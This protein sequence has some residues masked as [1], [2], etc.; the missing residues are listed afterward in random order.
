[1]PVFVI[2]SCMETKLFSMTLYCNM[3]LI[4]SI[5]IGTRNSMD[6]SLHLWTFI[7]AWPKRWLELSF[8]TVILSLNWT[9]LEGLISV[10]EEVISQ[11]AER[12]DSVLKGRR[13]FVRLNTRSPKDVTFPNSPITNDGYEALCW[14]MESNRTRFDLEQLWTQRLPSAIALRKPQYLDEC[15]EF[16]AFVRNGSLIAVSQYYKFNGGEGLWRTDRFKNN[17]WYS[18]KKFI[19]TEISPYAGYNEYVVDLYCPEGEPRILIEINPYI[20]ADGGCVSKY[21]IETK[22]G[23]FVT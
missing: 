2:I 8:P 1:M 17:L 11:T 5:Y 12:I 22:G 21:E 23:V 13:M 19:E 7:D 20:N 14:I 18:C 6:Y 15:Y 16:R 10:N 9:E 3:H 4:N